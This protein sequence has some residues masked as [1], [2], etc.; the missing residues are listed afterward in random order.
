M[1]ENI[2]DLAMSN[3]LWAVLFLG[4]LIYELK[5]SSIREKK[6]QNTIEKL[7]ENLSVVNEIKYTVDDISQNVK[8][9]KK[10]KLISEKT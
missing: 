2:L 5:D 8:K 1:W 9:S 6:Y 4:L 10:E 3:G 7:S